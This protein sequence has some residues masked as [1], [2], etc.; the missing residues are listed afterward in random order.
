MRCIDTEVVVEAFQLKVLGLRNSN[1][2]PMMQIPVYTNYTLRI[3]TYVHTR[4]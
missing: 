3:Y 1:M 4:N 2:L